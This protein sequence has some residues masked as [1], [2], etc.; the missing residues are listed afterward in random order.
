MSQSTLHKRIM[1]EAQKAA[2]Q[3]KKIYKENQKAM[4]R[5][6]V[7]KCQKCGAEGPTF[8]E[9]AGANMFQTLNS[10]HLCAKC[11]AERTGKIWN[12]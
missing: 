7:T 3:E 5:K 8:Q 2:K 11:H 1:R 6:P 10:H 12:A 4:R 9:A